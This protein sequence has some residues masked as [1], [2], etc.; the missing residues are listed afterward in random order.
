MKL[1]KRNFTFKFNISSLQ[2][3]ETHNIK[4][5]YQL[6]KLL[7]KIPLPEMKKESIYLSWIRVFKPLHRH[8]R[9]AVV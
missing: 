4:Y 8:S 1:W 9:W 3:S 6:K 2:L 7:D 5:Y